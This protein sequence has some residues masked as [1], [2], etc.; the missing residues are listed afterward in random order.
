[1]ENTYFTWE[2]FTA[3]YNA[4]IDSCDK[5]LN[6]ITENG[7]KANSLLSFDFHFLSDEKQKVEALFEFIKSSYT[8]KLKDII[9]RDDGLWELT[10]ETNEFALTFDN[11][12][13]WILDMYK[14][15]YEFDCTLDG[16][17]ALSD[18]KN[19]SFPD[20]NPDLEQQYFEKGLEL[21][22]GGDLS[23]AIINWSLV[24]EIKPDEVNALYSRAIVKD[25]LYCKLAALADYDK[26]IELVPNF[27]SALVNR[28]SL[29]D[30]MHDFEGAIADYN[31]IIENEKSD[32]K[33][34][35]QAYF[36]KGN[37][38]LQLENLADA[39]LNWESASKMGADYVDEQ[40]KRY[41]S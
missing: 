19:Q 2:D 13:F 18:V 4:Q 9:L 31:S 6:R 1:M 32:Q 14:R 12:L 22:K 30:S 25:E 40:I 15:G 26:A 8:Y 23:G 41:C 3:N 11:V 37:T 16:Y 28:G 38:Y 35:A 36:N 29:K 5:L 33:T 10:G 7:M 39:K 20:L 24:L 27:M 17:G 21:Y 34:V